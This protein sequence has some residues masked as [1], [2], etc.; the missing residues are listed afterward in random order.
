[1]HLA[2]ADTTASEPLIVRGGRL[3]LGRGRGFVDGR[4]LV[5][6]D[7]L[8]ADVIRDDDDAASGPETVDVAGAYVLPGLVDA[9]C[10]LMVRSAADVDAEHV[11]QATI[12]ALAAA[13]Q[14]LR[15][16]VTTVRDP[17]SRTR[18]IHAVT[19]ALRDGAVPGPRTFAAGPNITGSGAPRAWRNTFADGPDAVRASVRAE[20]RAGA[21]LIKL[22]LSHAPAWVRWRHVVRFLA[23]DEIAAAGAEARQLGLRVGCHCEGV[24]AARAA[25]RAGIDVIDHGIGLDREVVAEMAANGTCLVPTLWAF[26]TET[27]VDYAGTLDPADA[28]DY[29]ERVARVHRASFELALAAGVTVAAGS[30]PMLPAPDGTRLAREAVLLHDA[31]L[32]ADDVLD[33]VT[34]NGA[35]ALGRERE[36][37]R[38]AP[39]CRAD[40]VGY[41]RD[42]RRDLASLAT[43][44]WVRQAGVLA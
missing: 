23:D 25:V 34:L 24:E 29:E 31:G 42:P 14:L 15:A 30:D 32:P 1:M 28:P 11:A 4:A 2:V 19:R 40:L 20:Y 27:L 44:A 8:I 17:G 38:I 39:G 36:L 33:A 26:S 18:A 16:G 5:L 3:W 43:P 6:R 35:L 41:P 22:I 10:H 37:G 9:H 12:E 13:A 7:G 21:D